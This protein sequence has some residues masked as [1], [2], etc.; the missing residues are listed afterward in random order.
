MSVGLVEREW[1]VTGS[2]TSTV[3]INSKCGRNIMPCDCKRDNCVM[4]YNREYNKKIYIAG[5]KSNEKEIQ[6]IIITYTKNMGF[7]SLIN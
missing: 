4:T 2:W 6:Y 7:S 3:I 1:L 5:G